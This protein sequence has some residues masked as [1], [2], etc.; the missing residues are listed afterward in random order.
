MPTFDPQNLAE[1]T[2]GSWLAGP[3]GAIDGFCFDARQIQ[4]GQCFVALSGGARDGHDF[5]KQA[6][7]GGA[8]AALVEKP[9]A[10]ALPQLQV[11]DSLVALGAIA[12]AVRSQFTKPVVAV[13]GSC[14]KTSTK[15]MLRLLL[16]E[17]R[18]HATA[19]NWNNRIGVPMTLFGMQPARQDFAVIEAGINQP[20]EMA[21]LGQMIRADLNVLTNIGDAHLELL[22]SRENIAAEKSLLV[23]HAAEGSPVIL[24]AEVLGYPAYAALAARAIVIAEE[25]QD[26]PTCE[27]RRVIRYRIDPDTQADVHPKGI[28]P[29][30]RGQILWLDGQSYHI[31]SPSRGI[32]TNAALA[33]VV[34]HEL[35]ISGADILERIE[36]WRPSGHRGRIAELGGQTFYIDCYNANPSSMA[37][38]LEAFVHSAPQDVARYYILGAMNELGETAVDQHTA[39]GRLL[40]LRLQDRAAFVGPDLLT[41]AYR[42]GTLAS[43]ADPSQLVCAENIEKIKSTVAPFAGAIFLKGSRSYRLEL[44]VPQVLIP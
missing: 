44:L 41:Q 42:S 43:G 21:E 28:L 30:P 9:K 22:G 17:C 12:A 15:E 33:I 19:G 18:T 31:A 3:V 11:A 29:V 25:G 13:T 35:G 16:G 26:V 2:G 40:A 34:A 27:V 37:D 1:W 36:A 39:V 32:A 20:G 38:A 5:I 10:I 7:E 14:G 8:V 23:A 4:P 24:P 6:A